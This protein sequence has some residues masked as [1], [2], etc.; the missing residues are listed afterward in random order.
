MDRVFRLFAAQGFRGYMGLEYE[1]TGDPVTAVPAYLRRLK[2]YALK[3]S[4]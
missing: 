3:Y 2:E 1:A 4:G